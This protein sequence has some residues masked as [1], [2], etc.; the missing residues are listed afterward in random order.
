[1]PNGTVQNEG[2]WAT[3]SN[4]EVERRGVAA[5]TNEAALS[6]SSTPS[7]AQ[8][9]RDPRDRSNRLLDAMPRPQRRPVTCNTHGPICPFLADAITIE[10]RRLK[11]RH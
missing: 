4:D 5:P 8:R 10:E 11:H 7:L 6:P 2:R 1:M 9:R 3:G